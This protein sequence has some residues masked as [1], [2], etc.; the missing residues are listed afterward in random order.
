MQTDYTL[1]HPPRPNLD[2]LCP[3]CLKGLSR[4][5]TEAF[6][7]WRGSP[8]ARFH[9]WRRGLCLDN[10]K[11]WYGV[12]LTWQSKE[13]GYGDHIYPSLP[14]KT[15]DFYRWVILYTPMEISA[16]KWT[17][18]VKDRS[19]YYA[20]F[21]QQAKDQAQ[22][23]LAYKDW[24]KGNIASELI[25]EP[26]DTM[27][28]RFMQTYDMFIDTLPRQLTPEEEAERDARLEASMKETTEEL[29]RMLD[30]HLRS[31]L[32]SQ[33][34]PTVHPAWTQPEGENDESE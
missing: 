33:S 23:K 6:G 30:E 27:L 14:P 9:F 20:K 22:A 12:P 5:S 18:T 34:N 7:G 10:H 2:V 29:E 32:T 8:A 25:R 21:S 15:V 13:S 1:G 31:K 3:I 19:D 16:K 17:R 11:F 4:E 24:V 28:A 26:L